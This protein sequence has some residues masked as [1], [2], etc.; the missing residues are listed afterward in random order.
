MVRAVTLLVCCTLVAAATGD[1]QVPCTVDEAGTGGVCGS[2]S[3]CP[4]LERL[5]RSARPNTPAVQRLR[6]LVRRCPRSASGRIQIC[7]QNEVRRSVAPPRVQLPTSCGHGF[8]PRVTGGVNAFIGEFPWMASIQYTKTPDSRPEHGCGG[9]LITS[10]H[11]LTAAHC[12]SFLSTPQF[13]ELTPVSVILGELDFDSEIDCLPDMPSECADRPITV[14]ID[15]IFPHPHFQ[16]IRQLALPNDIAVV[17][18][19]RE[20]PFTDFIQPICLLTDFSELGDPTRTDITPDQMGIIAGWGRSNVSS[21]LGFTPVLQ[22]ARLPIRDLS[23]C[24]TSFRRSLPSR[25]CA[26]GGP[27]STDT[28]RGD[29]GGPL[30][31]SDRF[32]TTI[33]QTGISSFGTR[34]CGSVAGYTRVFDYRD[35]ILEQINK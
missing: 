16:N 11:V 20:V 15:A 9:T 22:K 29:S 14:D 13:P 3:D 8:S 6:S 35:W 28:C 26:G 32:G 19:A 18:L 4:E 24:E 27:N 25:L 10:R 33:F 2:L 30:M 12:V 17:R 5:A 21:E 7:C 34:V 23:E 1:D 31:V